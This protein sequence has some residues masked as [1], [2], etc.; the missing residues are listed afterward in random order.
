MVDKIIQET[1]PGVV[2]DRMR[3]FNYSYIFTLSKR[4]KRTEVELLRSE[5]EASWSWR[6][7][8]LDE[9][10]RKKIEKAISEL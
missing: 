3:K 7:G 6:R 9:G 4:D 2:I 1:D 5:I 10:L 8:G